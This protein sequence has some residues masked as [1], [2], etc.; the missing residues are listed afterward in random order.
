MSNSVSS[1]Q[2]PTPPTQP[3]PLSYLPLDAATTAL[4]LT[5]SLGPGSNALNQSASSQSLSSHGG[6]NSNTNA[7]GGNVNP[8][9]FLYPHPSNPHPS[10]GGM[11]LPYSGSQSGV[12]SAAGF[13]TKLDQSQACFLTGTANVELAEEILSH[14]GIP[15]QNTLQVRRFSDGET[16]VKIL[17]TVR[18]KDVL[19]K[20]RTSK[21][22]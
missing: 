8:S 21:C 15:R 16:F 19:R 5:N 4:D 18:G 7:T 17:T 10:G 6:L 22:I 13:Q 14:L 11:L 12:S 1:T 2:K 3:T 9:S 20:N